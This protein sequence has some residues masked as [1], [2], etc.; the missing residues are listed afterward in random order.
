MRIEVL[1][2]DKCGSRDGVV[3]LDGRRDGIPFTGDLCSSCW[4]EMIHVYGL[5]PGTRPAKKKFE[6]LDDIDQIPSKSPRK[7][8]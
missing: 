3:T 2:C 5:R 1:E 4:E 8:S 7:G 6:V